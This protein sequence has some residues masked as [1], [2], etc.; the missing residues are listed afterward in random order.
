MNQLDT[1]K[2]NPA[3]LS[4]EEKMTMKRDFMAFVDAHPVAAPRVGALSPYFPQLL[5]MPTLIAAAFVFVLG[6]TAYAA[7]K[8]LPNDL[9]YPIKISV[10]EPLFIE[11]PART[12]L[13]KASASNVLLSRRLE[14]AEALLQNNEVD[15][16][17]MGTIA[18]AV[19]AQ[20]RAVHAH[21]AAARESGEITDALDVGSDVENTLEAHTEVLASLANDLPQNEAV[22]TLIDV[23][24]DNANEAEQVS[25]LIEQEAA[26]S[27]TGETEDYMSEIK[28]EAATG[29]E[30]LR[31]KLA[32]SPDLGDELVQEATLLIQK[33][34]ESYSAANTSLAAGDSGTALSQLRDSLQSVQQ[35]VILFESNKDLAESAN[36]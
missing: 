22:Q 23:V 11:A 6:G 19:E 27:T 33:A 35:G 30:S 7:E 26:S 20:T 15:P 14:E 34:D 36:F 25:E 12:E 3:S 4:P 13:A 18:I 21:I 5:R 31:A 9:L 8:S 32:A 16:E 28:A 24:S 29:I 17:T 1:S 2:N 10:I